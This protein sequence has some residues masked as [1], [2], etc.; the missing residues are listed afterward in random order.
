MRPRVVFDA[1]VVLSA[2]LFSTGR[3]SWLRGAWRGQQVVPLVCK[4]TVEEILRAMAYPKFRL[5]V[6]EREELL[7]EYL[8]Y[9]EVVNL[10]AARPD[11]PQC[12]D[13][14]DQVFLELAH[15]TGAD[16]LVTGDRDLLAMQRHFP[17][18]IITPEA[19]ARILGSETAAGPG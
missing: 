12:R 1:N 8:P 9:T 5:S 19:F 10:P 11:L 6:S 2:L 3:L 15:C 4:E 18:V 17:A 13:A 7:A 16:H 14:Q